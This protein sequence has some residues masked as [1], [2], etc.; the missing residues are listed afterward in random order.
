MAVATKA[1]KYDVT[2]L[3][4]A[5]AGVRRTE[6]AAREMPVLGQI[7]ERLAKERPYAGVRIAACL[8]VTTE[9]ANLAL[10]LR[11]GGAEVALCASNPLSTQDDAAA[12][13][14]AREGISVFARK[15]EDRDTYYRHINAVLE[16]KP[17][18]TMDDGADVVTLLH[19]KRRELLPDVR[20]GTE[21]TT[22]GVIR[23]RA[24]AE[25]G[26]LKYPIVAVNEA[27]T[28]HMFDNQY[29][30]G[31]SAIDGL[32]RATNLLLA[33]KSAVVCGYGWVGRGVA[34]RLRGMGAIVTIC[35]VDPLRGLEAA[36]DG[37]Q[38]ATVAEAV[39]RGD[40][41]FTATGNLNVIG[42]AH[43]AC[44]KDGAIL[45]NVGHF[46]DEIELGAL[47][48][49]AKGRRVIRPFVEEFQLADKKKVFVL[50]EGRLL[51]HAAAEANPAAVMD[52]SFANQAL[53]IEYLLK[54]GKELAPRVYPVPRELDEEIAR[55]KLEA[56]GMR[57]DTMSAAQAEY[58]RS[59]KAGT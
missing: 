43:F 39:T 50:A 18:I 54:H 23:L 33:G 6:W 38:V 58:A 59:W 7:R 19:T 46:N 57:I 5:D 53:S 3:D 21:E 25:E 56:M 45:A 10:A 2:D 35:E 14:V 16:I 17:H 1:P 22:T 12:A 41:F 15:G 37:F 28:K 36:M 29:G 49:M 34:S 52:M 48:E 4:L 47:A 44:L 11:D 42:R 20:G 27:Q 31:Q 8:H 9:T 13:L 24:M 26:V 55:R 32:L 30:T 51:N 40:V